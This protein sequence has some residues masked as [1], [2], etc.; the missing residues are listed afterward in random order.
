MSKYQSSNHIVGKVYELSQFNMNAMIRD[1]EQHTQRVSA[2][3][4][5]ESELEN[6]V[7]YLSKLYKREQHLSEK[8]HGDRK[9]AEKLLAAVSAEA[10]QW[11]SIY[12]DVRDAAQERREA[13]DER[14]KELEKVLATALER[15]R[16]EGFH[17]SASTLSK[18]AAESRQA[19]KA[20]PVDTNNSAKYQKE[21]MVDTSE[22]H[23]LVS[24]SKTDISPP[25]Y[26]SAR[27]AQLE[28]ALRIAMRF[29][30]SDA[31]LSL[32]QQAL[33]GGHDT[34]SRINPDLYAPTYNA[35][36][37]Q[38]ETALARIKNCD[39][40]PDL[41]NHKY[42]DAWRLIREI[43]S[44][45]DA[46]AV[47]PETPIN[48]GYST[49]EP[50]NSEDSTA[51]PSITRNS[52]HKYPVSTAQDPFGIVGTEP[53]GSNSTDV[54]AQDKHDN[55]NG[56]CACAAW[57]GSVA[58]QDPYACAA[59]GHG[60]PWHRTETAETEATRCQASADCS[61]EEYVSSNEGKA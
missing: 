42:Y 49:M 25:T 52:N 33:R 11:K 54:A 4:L 37:A 26:Q 6:E 34:Q 8:H 44:E 43:F 1:I 2:L 36:I 59:C 60:E 23:I 24:E 29:V 15:L 3:E 50:S 45:L 13:Q 22:Q 7:E 53:A 14:I 55:P 5:R 39:P 58:T 18:E 10:D 32:C 61:C 9:D 51:N 31:T 46:A 12:Y 56:P 27:V 35:R 30:D 16:L 47:Q 48:E 19:H 38:L 21:A 41:S 20:A 40:Y 57:H 28:N 17:S